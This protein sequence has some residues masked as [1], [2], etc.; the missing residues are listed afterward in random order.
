MNSNYPDA[1]GTDWAPEPLATDARTT[2]IEPATRTARK[3]TKMT[4]YNATKLHAAIDADD[5]A[6]QALRN[7][8]YDASDARNKLT[9][10]T[11]TAISD[12][13]LPPD[14]LTVN[15]GKVRRILRNR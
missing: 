2:P 7:A 9:S 13:L 6:Q 8:Q 10:V 11:L 1:D 5:A 12:G 14:V 3:A 15:V 4:N